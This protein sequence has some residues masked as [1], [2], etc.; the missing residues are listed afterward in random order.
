MATALAVKGKKPDR[1]A[2]SALQT[3][4]WVGT[5]KRGIKLR[6]RENLNVIRV[7]ADKDFANVHGYDKANYKRKIIQN[8]R[9][10]SSA[11]I[12]AKDLKGSYPADY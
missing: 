6:M 8:K 5:D 1:S 7:N 9:N 3:F 12:A 4:A 2:V 11:V 10:H